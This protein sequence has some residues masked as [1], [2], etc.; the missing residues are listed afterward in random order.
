MFPLCTLQVLNGY[1]IGFFKGDQLLASIPANGGSMTAGRA[2][3]EDPDRVSS[4][5][6]SWA[7]S[8]AAPPTGSIYR[9]QVANDSE[10]VW[11]EVALSYTEKGKTAIILVK[12]DVAPGRYVSFELCPCDKLDGYAFSVFVNGTRAKLHDDALQF[13]PTGRLNARRALEFK[14]DLDP[15]KDHWLIETR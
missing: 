3:A 14:A 8:D 6:D 4:H 15:C 9:V 11:D 7:I 5:S 2:A 13:P 10:D 12:E 1:T